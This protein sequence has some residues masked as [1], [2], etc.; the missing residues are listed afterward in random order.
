MEYN[1]TFFSQNVAIKNN[2]NGSKRNIYNKN[3]SNKTGSNKNSS[4]SML[5]IQGTNH[6]VQDDNFEYSLTH[7]K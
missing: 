3:D 1:S 7:G 4:K 5:Y 2:N 6:N